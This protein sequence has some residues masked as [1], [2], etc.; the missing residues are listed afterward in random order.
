MEASNHFYVV[1]N[2][3]RRLVPEFTTKKCHVSSVL[4]D[5]GDISVVFEAL[6]HRYDKECAAAS[7]ELMD[8][9]NNPPTV[10]EEN[11]VIK[12]LG[13]AK[14]ENA[15]KSKEIKKINDPEIEEEE[16]EEDDDEDYNDE[17]DYSSATPFAIV[18]IQLAVT[19]HLAIFAFIM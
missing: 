6:F 8:I 10:L 14:K 5:K 1:D 3:I 18:S 16:E 13:T 19:L 15:L 7:K 12:N 9:I 17:E 11:T 4:T 2:F